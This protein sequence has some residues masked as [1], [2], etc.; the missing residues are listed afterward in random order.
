MHRYRVYGLTVESWIP[1]PELEAAPPDA[2]VDVVFRLGD[3]PNNLP[4]CRHRGARYQAVPGKLLVWLDG[5]ARFLAL[6]GREIIVARV[7]GTLESDVRVLLLCSP[8]G[9][10]LLQR[11]L[12]PLHA[13]AISTPRGAVLFMGPSG[14][15]KSTLAAQF[16]L[17]G[18]PLLADDI[19]VI[20]LKED[21]PAL[22]SPG[23]PQF[24]LWPDAASQLG[25]DPARLAKMRPNLEKLT[26]TIGEEFH[27]LPVPLAAIYVLE[28]GSRKEVQLHPITGLNRLSHLLEHTYRLDFVP[29]L[30]LRE[31]HFRQVSRLAEETRLTRV[32]R[33]GNE[34]ALKELADRIES[35]FGS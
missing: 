21:G 15:G 22:V 10:L 14:H 33:S 16:R 29:G 20:T 25:A 9:G 27:S 7:E 11:G 30:G 26:M 4:G 6:D 31:T 34:F 2:P 5:V 12:L 23:Y 19:S 28:I 32:A 1:F 24:K 13:S 17:R 8:M 18:F 35:D 3:V